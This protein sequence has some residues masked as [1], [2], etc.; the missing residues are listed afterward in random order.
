[1]TWYH[2]VYTVAA[3]N[4]FEFNTLCSQ[5]VCAL[6]T[7]QFHS[8]LKEKEA[9]QIIR[10]KFTRSEKQTIFKHETSKNYKRCLQIAHY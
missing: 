2:L 5:I 7:A 3:S 1:M 4:E 10:G 6:N 9:A 8:K